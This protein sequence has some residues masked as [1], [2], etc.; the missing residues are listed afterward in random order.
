MFLF[1][2]FFTFVALLVSLV[3]CADKSTVDYEVK[4]GFSDCSIKKDSRNNFADKFEM[5]TVDYI[6][7]DNQL[8]VTIIDQGCVSPV[9]LL[10]KEEGSNIFVAYEYT[11]VPHR[12]PGELPAPCIKEVYFDITVSHLPVNNVFFVPSSDTLNWAKV[13]GI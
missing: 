5:D 12:V 3:S 7:T 10:L 6:L 13:F 1:F 11:S 4:S 9:K 8:Q 2:R